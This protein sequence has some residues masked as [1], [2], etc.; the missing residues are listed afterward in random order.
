[1]KPCTL[2]VSYETGRSRSGSEYLSMVCGCGDEI[3]VHSLRLFTRKQ[4]I[5]SM[6]DALFLHRRGVTTSESFGLS[7]DASRDLTEEEYAEVLARM[8]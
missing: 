5:S 2:D 3:A 8:A 6:E 4:A 7:P 1:M